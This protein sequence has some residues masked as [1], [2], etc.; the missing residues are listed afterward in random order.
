MA[1]ESKTRSNAKGPARSALI[2]TL[3]R[4][5]IAVALLVVASGIFAVLFANAPDPP[6]SEEDETRPTVS[7]VTVRPVNAPRLWNAYGT[8][9]AKSAANVGV[10]VPGVVEERPES[11]EPGN[12]VRK[13]DVILRIASREYRDVVSQT[14]ARIA[15]IGA[16]LDALDTEYESAQETLALA[17]EAVRITRNELTR[18]EDAQTTAGVNQ[19]ELDRLR[20]QL[21][22]FRRQQEDLQRQ[23]DLIPAR[24]LRLQAQRQQEDAALRLAQLNVERTEVRA[25]IDGVLQQVLVDDGERVA[26]GQTVARVV[27]MT[28]IEVPVRTPLTAAPRL[29]AGDDVRLSTGGAS[30]E[31]WTGVIARV[32]PEADSATRT[33]TVFVV[34]EQDP[35]DPRSALLRPGQ[36]LS[37]TLSSADARERVVLPRSSIEDDRVVLLDDENKA[38]FADVRIVYH[39]D[40]SFRAIHPTETQ[41]TAIEGDVGAGDRVVIDGITSLTEGMSLDPVPVTADDPGNAFATTNGDD[42]S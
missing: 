17:S 15:A 32:A 25:P 26:P 34:V 2:I 23:V 38:R 24:R 37:A 42:R 41:W 27:D 7:F 13:G 8:A 14:E 19:I 11:I 21:T 5:G 18:F 12:T 20:R 9:R 35:D 31:T 36:Y 22:E 33:I 6:K 3:V 1:A 28:A 30:P 40:A 39:L 29:R 10:E 16:D 4:G